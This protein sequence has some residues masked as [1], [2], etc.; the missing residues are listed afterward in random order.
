MLQLHGFDAESRGVDGPSV[1]LSD[2]TRSPA[3]W[4]EAAADC[5]GEALARRTAL[6]PRDANELGGTSNAQAKL[7]RALGSRSFLHLELSLELRAELAR[8]PALR[9]QVLLCIPETVP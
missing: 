2:A 4:V 7:L 6:Y 8:E 5:L 3:Q 9:K 1:V